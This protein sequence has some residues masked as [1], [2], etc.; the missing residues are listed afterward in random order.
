[1]SESVAANWRKTASPSAKPPALVHAF[2]STRVTGPLER[3]A[4]DLSRHLAVGDWP[5]GADQPPEDVP[6]PD[7]YFFF[8]AAFF[9][10]AFFFA[11]FFLAAIPNHLLGLMSM[12]RD[13]SHQ[14][15]SEPPVLRPGG[16]YTKLPSASRGLAMI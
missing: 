10:V 9:F 14:T 2:E 6:G 12:R 13:R 15:M 3:S 11:A 4:R 7:A 5:A 16:R 1:M 8:F